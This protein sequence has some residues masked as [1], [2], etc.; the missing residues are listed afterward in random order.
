MKKLFK[1]TSVL[2]GAAMLAS[3]CAC[4]GAQPA[5]PLKEVSIWTGD[6][7]S[8]NVIKGIVDEFNE[9]RGKKLGVKLVYTVKEGDYNQQIELAIAS[10]QAPDIF[11]CFSVQKYAE[12][13]NIVAINDLPGG[14]EY[15]DSIL[16]DA[17]TKRAFVTKFDGKS[18]KVPYYVNTFGIVYN[19][20][21]FKEAGIVDEKGEA[22]P[23]ETFEEL[24][25][26]AKKLTD[27]SK[28]RYGLI[29]PFKNNGTVGHFYNMIFA[30]HGIKGYDPVTGAYDYSA[31]EPAFKLLLDM[32]H[33]GSLYPGCEAIDN[34]MARALFAEGQIGMIFGGS[35][36]VAVFTSQFPAKCSWS[37]APMPI[38]NKNKAYLQ[39]MSNDGGLS[40][41]KKSV[42][43]VGGEALL[44]IYK[45]FHSDEVLQSLYEQGVSIPYKT[46]LIE[47]AKVKDDVHPAWAKFGAMRAISREYP[48]EMPTDLEGA[49]SI[50]EIFSTNIWPENG[51]MTAL[52]ADLGKR[53]ND[54]IAK[55]FA[56]ND[57]LKREDYI[58]EDYNTRR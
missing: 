25:E 32:K 44:E 35:Y 8:K 39:R 11:K 46:E 28:K 27:A 14:Q 6:S 45:W 30:S 2:I 1:I 37:V 7:H 43:R 21:M 50:K 38:E 58:I 41:N 5:G 33:D 53:S 48:P 29:T 57:N 34:D 4:G 12:N 13:G 9:S 49:P 23:P 18:Y 51:D 24:R 36:D 54:G 16:T 56:V 10:D 31:Y 47:K 52:L 20:D 15:L 22:K 19:E 40:I 42:D 26:C 3:L 55:K 17:E